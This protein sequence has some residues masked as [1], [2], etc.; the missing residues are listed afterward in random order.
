[1]ANVGATTAD[2]M[3]AKVKELA[4]KGIQLA[5]IGFGMSYNDELMERLANKGDGFYAY[6]D[7]ER[8]A[9]RLFVDRLTTTLEA[10]ALDAKV[11]LELDPRAVTRYRLIGFENRAVADKDFR[12]DTVDGG[13]IGVGHSVTALYEVQLAPGAKTSVGTVRLHWVD[14]ASKSPK[15]VE[16]TIRVDALAS[17]FE[18][19]APRFRLAAVVAAFA[20][21]LRG[22]PF[23]AGYDF[24]DVRMHATRVAKAITGDADVAELPGLVAKASALHSGRQ[25]S[26]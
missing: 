24:E 15:D 26:P 18:E 14:P 8:E 7:G 23:A 1:M 20:E 6:V 12:D 17:T 10:Q 4:G 19:A 9:R 11:Q 2:P 3:L 25:P 16:H 22:S 5:T 13:E 21:L